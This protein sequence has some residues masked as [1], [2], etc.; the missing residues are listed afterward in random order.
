MCIKETESTQI[1]LAERLLMCFTKPPWHAIYLIPTGFLVF[2]VFY[3]VVDNNGSA[4]ALVFVF[5]GILLSLRIAAAILRR[6]VPVSS[7]VQQVWFESRV[8]A[9]RY[10]S[11]HWQKLFWV[12]CGIG[13]SSVLSDDVQGI[14]LVMTTVCLVSGA[15]GFLVWRKASIAE[16]TA[17]A[18]VTRR[19]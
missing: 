4:W 14:Q 8:L 18:K 19:T 15:L 2:P 9:K 16:R 10:D 5:F 1:G 12:G 13:I 3:L 6:V 7:E 11:Y 17:K